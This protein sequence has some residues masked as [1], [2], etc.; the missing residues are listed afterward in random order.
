MGTCMEDPAGCCPATIALTIMCSSNQ[1]QNH[2][3]L[4]CGARQVDGMQKLGSLCPELPKVMWMPAPIKN[5]PKN[6]A[7]MFI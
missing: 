6:V 4:C 1:P 5:G 2:S 7:D 3:S